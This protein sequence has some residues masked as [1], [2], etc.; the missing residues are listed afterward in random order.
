MD[1]RSGQPLGDHIGSLA[2]HDEAP[3]AAQIGVDVAIVGDLHLGGRAHLRD[4]DRAQAG[5]GA[6]GDQR[7][8]QQRG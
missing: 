5:A 8:Q 4:V 3:A 6:G 7:Q 1:E 2:A